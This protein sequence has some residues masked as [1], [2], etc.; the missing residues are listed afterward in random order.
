VAVLCWETGPLAEPYAPCGGF[1]VVMVL[2]ASRYASPEG[3]SK[4]A[5]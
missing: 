5:Q 3:L 2:D 4:I 1:S